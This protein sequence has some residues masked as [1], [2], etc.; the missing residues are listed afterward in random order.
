MEPISPTIAELQSLPSDDCLA[1]VANAVGPGS[2]VVSSRR[3]PGGLSNGMHVIELKHPDG[4]RQHVVLRRFSHDEGAPAV[5]AVREWRVLQLLREAGIPAPEW[6]W[7]GSK[8][9]NH[10]A[11]KIDD[12]RRVFLRYGLGRSELRLD[13]QEFVRPPLRI[14][15]NRALRSR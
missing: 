6:H 7:K 10:P 9:I 12:G 8:A 2:L 15:K 3:L 4:Q 14:H 5:T 11:A 13:N 1:A